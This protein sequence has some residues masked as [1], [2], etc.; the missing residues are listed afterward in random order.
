MQ[1]KN[2]QNEDKTEINSKHR[3]GI[4]PKR[5]TSEKDANIVENKIGVKTRTKKVFVF[6][7]MQIN[8][9]SS[10]QDIWIFYILNIFPL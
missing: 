8:L 9:S 1:S 4:P 2:E 5:N 3:G 10:E 6:V 7:F